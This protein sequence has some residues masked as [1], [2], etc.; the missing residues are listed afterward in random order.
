MSL[1]HMLALG[2]DPSLLIRGLCGGW[3]RFDL[4]PEL[5]VGH[6]LATFRVH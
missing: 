2:S 6:S 1:S 3:R 5:W 4:D